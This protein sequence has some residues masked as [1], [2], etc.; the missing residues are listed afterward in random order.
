MKFLHVLLLSSLPLAVI[1]ALIADEKDAASYSASVAVSSS[2]FQEQGG[3]S[4][5]D[6]EPLRHQQN[7]WVDEME[8]DWEEE[9]DD[10]DLTTLQQDNNME[11][12]TKV[13]RQQ[14]QQLEPEPGIVQRILQY[15]RPSGTFVS[16]LTLLL[17][18]K[19]QRLRLFR[20]CR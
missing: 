9:L 12:A 10:D 17:S 1:P 4:P 11:E 13:E 7:P 16:S 14:Q 15:W 6:E 8:Q 18:N 3:N 19:K 2:S 5:D 20:S